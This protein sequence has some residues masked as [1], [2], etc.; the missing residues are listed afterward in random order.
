MQGT[1]YSAGPAGGVTLHSVCEQDENGL[2]LLNQQATIED[3]SSTTWL[4]DGSSSEEALQQLAGDAC[5][6]AAETL[7]GLH[8]AASSDSNEAA[9]RSDPSH[10]HAATIVHVAS[11]AAST[12]AA[13]QQHQQGK[14]LRGLSAAGGASQAEAV[15]A[16]MKAGAGGGR[17][18]A[19][20]GCMMVLGSVLLLVL[21]FLAAGMIMLLGVQEQEH[22]SHD[23][24]LVFSEAF[25]DGYALPA[26]HFAM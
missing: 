21:S 3:S 12:A 19:V 9:Y 7:T 14:Q 8:A 4:S 24:V 25:N 16:V 26:R 17:S 22:A 2:E 23:D 20:L 13:G 18:T 11:G 1:T 6:P 5:L 15:D 10:A